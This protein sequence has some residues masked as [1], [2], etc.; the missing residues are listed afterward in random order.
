M[1]MDI[2]S[3]LQERGIVELVAVTIDEGIAG[4]RAEG[5]KLPLKLPGK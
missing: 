4:Y 1:T 3:N 2:L 5:V